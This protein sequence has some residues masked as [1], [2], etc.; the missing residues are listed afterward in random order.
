MNFYQKSFY[1]SRLQA[2]CGSQNARHMQDFCGACK[3][4]FP[5]FLTFSGV[6]HFGSEM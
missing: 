1:L 6:S 4:V 2:D 5:D 3:K